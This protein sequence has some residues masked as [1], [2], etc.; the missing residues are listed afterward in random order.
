MEYIAYD[1]QML[2]LR[3]GCSLCLLMICNGCLLVGRGETDMRARLPLLLLILAGNGGVW[4]DNVGGTRQNIV[5]DSDGGYT[6]ILLA[7]DESVPEDLA[8]IDRIQVGDQVTG[9][10]LGAMLM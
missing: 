1:G 9:Q 2:I 6:S 7:I 8:L 10:R 3:A 5:H 4:C